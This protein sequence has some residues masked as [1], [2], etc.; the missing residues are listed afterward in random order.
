VLRQSAATLGI[1]KLKLRTGGRDRLDRR[2]IHIMESPW[3]LR[4]RLSLFCWDKRASDLDLMSEIRGQIGAR[5]HNPH[6]NGS[7]LPAVADHVGVW[8][9]AAAQTAGYAVLLRC[10]LGPAALCEREYARGD[11]NHCD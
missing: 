9:A 10:I 6:R 3:H 2:H 4:V 5:R 1:S 7:V 8:C 11:E